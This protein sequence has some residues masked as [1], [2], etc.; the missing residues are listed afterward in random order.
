MAQGQSTTT[1]VSKFAAELSTV[2]PADRP[3]RPSGATWKLPAATRSV[4]AATSITLGPPRARKL[5]SSE[6]S[7]EVERYLPGGS[8]AAP[9]H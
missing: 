6:T 4:A 2:P 8:F 1:G 3:M 7:P 5:P 9:I